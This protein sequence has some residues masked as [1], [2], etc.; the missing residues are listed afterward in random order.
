MEAC[1]QDKSTCENRG[2]G[3]VTVGRIKVS[4]FVDDSRDIIEMF[5]MEDMMIEAC[6]FCSM[7]SKRCVARDFTTGI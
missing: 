5:A 6:L 3:G 4:C 7:Y 2:L 1:R